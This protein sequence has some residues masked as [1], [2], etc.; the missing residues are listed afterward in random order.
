VALLP[1]GSG[2]RYRLVDPLTGE[3]RLVDAEL[4]REI[5]REAVAFYRPLPAGPV[6]LRKLVGFAAFGLGRDVLTVIGMGVAVALLA[7]L[8]PLATGLVFGTVVPD[9]ETR[10]LVELVLGLAAAASGSAL[11]EAMRAIALIR[12]EGRLDWAIQ[13]GMMDRLLRLPAAF[14]KAFTA[15]DLANR[16]LGADAIR[17]ALTGTTATSL[18]SGVFSAAT[19]TLLVVLSPKL[20]VL[21]AGT[22][23]LAAA[24]TVALDAARLRHERTRLDRAGKIHG[25]VVQFVIGVAKLRVAAAEKRAAAV[26]ARAAARQKGEALRAR[27]C[28][29]WQQVLNDAFPVLAT[30]AV[31]LGAADLLPDDAVGG[32][33]PAAFALGD[34]LAFSAAFGQLLAALSSFAA[35]LSQGLVAVPLF[36]RCRPILTALPETEPVSGREPARLRGEVEVQRVT[37]RYGKD[38]PAVLEDVSLSVGP[39]EFVALV[40]PSGSGKSTLLRLL[41][42]F[43]RPETGAVLFDGRPLDTLDVAAVRRDIGVVLQDGKL[44]PGSLLETIVGH[45]GLG[46][47]DA[48]E[49]ARRVGLDAD[50][51]AMPMRMHTMLMEGATT[52][53]GGQRQKLMLARALVHRPRLLLLD[54]ATSALD[55]RSQG[56]V[57]EGIARL[58]VTRIVVAHR[59]TTIRSA[60][61]VVVLERGRIVE[62]GTYCE[63]VARGGRFAELARRQ[64]L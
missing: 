26:W 37:F 51:E 42:G 19:L 15:G 36:E 39:G 50:I 25:L 28:G 6:G 56:V 7:L 62:S 4:H 34:F 53:S 10:L 55:N 5:A 31:F 61:R 20:A 38:E 41:L 47:D 43:E 29:V 44:S 64:W 22:T 27:R 54:E 23:G 60:D 1:T 9:G 14:F 18:V 11:F 57:T 58:K 63:L 21:A 30:A 3:S 16:L 33:G 24:L 17:Q 12:I 13:A 59:L 2:S 8:I 49:A 32:R 40:G 46:I 52:L 48:W 35:A 45:T